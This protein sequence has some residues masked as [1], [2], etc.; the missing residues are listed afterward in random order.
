MDSINNS[1]IAY[2]LL[3]DGHAVP[4]TGLSPDEVK[5][6]S[7][8]AV[9][10]PGIQLKHVSGLNA[11]LHCLG[12]DGDLGD[13]RDKHFPKIRKL[14]EDYGLQ[15]YHNLFEVGPAELTFSTMSKQ[16]RAVADRIFF[17]PAP[18][19]KRVFTGYGYDWSD[20]QEGRRYPFRGS[21]LQDGEV[22]PEDTEQARIWVCQHR[23]ALLG[24]LTF[25][26]DHLLDLGSSGLFEAATY[27][28]ASV[29]EVRRNKV[30]D[31]QRRVA[32]ALRQVLDQSEDG[33]L[34][35][36]PV[37]ENLVFL[38]GPSGTY[39]ILW[40]NL[41]Q[42][43][44]ATP[45]TTWIPFDL[46]PLDTPSVLQS[47]VDFT[48]WYYFLLNAWEEKDSH[49]AEKHYYA[50]GGRMQP[51]YPGSP[52]VLQQYL[53]DQGRYGL[54]ASQLRSGRASQ[55]F[56]TVQL[57]S[58][59]ALLASEMVT[60]QEFRKFADQGY[61]DRREGEDWSAANG[62]NPDT[63]PVGC[64]LADAFAYC[65]WVEKELGVSV[66]LLTLAEHRELRPFA[67]E[68]YKGLSE[69][70]F[71]WEDFPPRHGLQASVEWSEARFLDPSPEVPEF[72]DKHGLIRASRKRWIPSENW[73]PKGAWRKEM[74]WADH[75]GLRFL[76]AWDAY[77]WCQ[78]GA[79][80]GRYW[81]GP[82][83]GTTSWGE[84]KNAKI[85]FRLVIEM[86]DGTSEGGN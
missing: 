70:D 9:L 69:L 12:F 86:D 40:R 43:P 66:R 61:F 52:A 19:P 68:H 38:K 56:K 41:R 72:P 17:G 80:A 33:W 35:I 3:R 1:I 75:A 13:Y 77:E 23:T 49:E 39:D 84:Y 63:L 58:G 44:P 6:S 18:M 5:A 50:N 57:K 34:E 8:H 10:R 14:M 26:S 74:P 22:A 47:K 83:G 36:V 51:H 25:F 81:E 73:P 55:G 76:D 24:N 78:E 21:E 46:N 65:A 37:T 54:Q 48:T 85:G 27:F 11:L 31:S 32:E 82:L 4:I 67:A 62:F 45:K 29:T 2:L 60:V 53:R 20:W 59:K 79:V 16:R 64:T 30:L 15:E 28:E 7:K 71:P 42:G